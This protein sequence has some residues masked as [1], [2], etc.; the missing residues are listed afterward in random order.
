MLTDAIIQSGLT[1]ANFAAA[2]GISRSYLSM[3]EVGKKVPSLDLAVRIQ[4]L[5]NNRVPAESWVT[6][7]NIMAG[8]QACP[9]GIAG[10]R[11][12]HD[13]PIIKQTHEPSNASQ[14]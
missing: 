1:R 8:G 7:P 3:L 5:T 10:G 6:Q 2:L 9:E 11:C 13:A 4:R 14:D 12:G